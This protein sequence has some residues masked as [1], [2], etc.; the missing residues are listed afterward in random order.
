MDNFNHKALGLKDEMPLVYTATSKHYFYFRMFISRFV[1]EKNAVPLNPFM[2]FDYF[3][4]D[5]L[6][7][8]KV[9]AA[10]NNL[11]RRADEIWVFGPVSDGIL[12]EILLAKEAGKPIKYFKI[13]NSREIA[14]INKAEAEM[15]TDVKEYK[16]KL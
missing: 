16:N 7:R 14:E 5:T 9:R 12:A 11:V 3:L 10:N 2:I 6:D 15:E 13:I 8:D 1:L 4:L